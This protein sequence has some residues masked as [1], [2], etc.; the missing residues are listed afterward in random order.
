MLSRW[1]WHGPGPHEQIRRGRLNFLTSTEHEAQVRVSTTSMVI[2]TASR[3]SSRA[4]VYSG[5]LYQVRAASLLA[6]WRMITPSATSPSR[7]VTG[8]GLTSPARTIG[9]PPYF[10]IVGVAASR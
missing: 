10:N 7:A 5:L 3:R 6:N 9:V 2:S 1:R 4:A 8:D